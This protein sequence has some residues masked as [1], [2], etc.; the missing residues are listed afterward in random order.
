[1]CGS[2]SSEHAGVTVIAPS[3]RLT[4]SLQ[5]YAA[6]MFVHRALGRKQFKYCSDQTL[7]NYFFRKTWSELPA[8]NASIFNRTAPPPLQCFTLR[9]CSPICGRVACNAESRPQ[10]PRG[11]GRVLSRGQGPLQAWLVSQLRVIIK[12]NTFRIDPRGPGARPH[13]RATCAARARHPHFGGRGR[14]ALQRQRVSLEL[15]SYIVEL[16]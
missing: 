1:M 10:F 13:A 6:R 9:V 14:M 3:L 11:D 4:A 5:R 12:A 15:L 8:E 16:W 7:L 2:E